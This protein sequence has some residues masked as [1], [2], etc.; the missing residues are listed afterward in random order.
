MLVVPFGSGTA[1]TC[2]SSALSS[3]TI[4]LT[5]VVP[6]TF[7]AGKGGGLGQ[8]GSGGGAKGDGGGGAEGGGGDGG[9]GAG[10]GGGLGDVAVTK[11]NVKG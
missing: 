9:G 1:T 11:T 5:V 2:R 3:A 8:G 10:G 4:K 6:L 7:R